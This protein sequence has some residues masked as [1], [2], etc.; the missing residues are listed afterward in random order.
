M[1]EYDN[2]EYTVEQMSLICHR[3]NSFDV[4][5]IGNGVLVKSR[6]YNFTVFYTKEGDVK[7]GVSVNDQIFKRIRIDQ[8]MAIG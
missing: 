7:I 4:A 1:I 3:K 2:Y 6:K 8:S 5:R